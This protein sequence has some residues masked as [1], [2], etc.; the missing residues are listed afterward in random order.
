MVWVSAELNT[1]LTQTLK[2]VQMYQT[3]SADYM[4]ILQI[5]IQWW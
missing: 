1:S 2:S 3:H 5:C 4:T